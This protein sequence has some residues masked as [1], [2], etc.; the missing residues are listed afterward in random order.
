MTPAP[1]LVSPWSD[2][3]VCV[4]ACLAVSCIPLP[5]SFLSFELFSDFTL[6]LQ[7]DDPKGREGP[8]ERCPE[9][10]LTCTHSASELRRE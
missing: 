2:G 7:G 9:T 1:Y 4:G 6:G 10:S 8:G 3:F 5:P